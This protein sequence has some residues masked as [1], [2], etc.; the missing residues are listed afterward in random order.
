MLVP[1]SG[2][3]CVHALVSCIQGRRTI[4]AGTEQVPLLG[5]EW[6]QAA[7]ARHGTCLFRPISYRHELQN[8]A[9]R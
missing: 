8:G 9:G 4:W 1:E 5:A 6:R 3:C 7:A 2:T